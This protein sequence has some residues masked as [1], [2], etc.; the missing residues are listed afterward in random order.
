MSDEVRVTRLQDRVVR[1]DGNLSA[2]YAQIQ[3]MGSDGVLE[4]V[5]STS[6]LARDDGLFSILVE[7]RPALPAGE[8]TPTEPIASQSPSPESPRRTPSLW[9]SEGTRRATALAGMVLASC[10]LVVG[11]AFGLAWL[12]VWIWSLILAHL[13]GIVATVVLAL[14]AAVW[15]RK[16][17][18]F[19]SSPKPA[20]GADEASVPEQ[21]RW[22]GASGVQVIPQDEPFPEPVISE[23][24]HWLTGRVVSQSI[25]TPDA[26]PGDPLTRRW[27]ATLKDPRSGQSVGKWRGGHIDDADPSIQT[28][29]DDDRCAISWLLELDDPK[30]W[31]RTDNRG[32]KHRSYRALKAKYG[33]L[34]VNDVIRMNDRGVPLHKI[35]A[36]IEPKLRKQGHIE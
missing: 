34:F 9:R 7:L 25:S 21:G 30:G 1:L 26:S 10:G 14:G 5:V 18:P 13:A 23:K 19:V 2:L 22:I 33:K 24:R 36:R 11:V 20:L 4:R 16:R 31:K 27:L 3:A 12:A 15:L 6:P 32:T 8:Q 28:G 29:C 17:A 35:A